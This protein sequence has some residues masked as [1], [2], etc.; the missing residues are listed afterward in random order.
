M[1]SIALFSNNA[2]STLALAINSGATTAQLSS[3]TGALFPT[4]TGTNYFIGTFTDAATGAQNE[5]VKVTGRSG[6]VITF[7]RAQE[8]TSAR[9]WAAGDN[10]E[11][12]WTAGEA[13]LMLQQGQA[14]QQAQNYGV[15]VGSVDTLAVTLS[16]APTAYSDLQ[17][18]PV[19]VLINGPNATT[20]PT[21]NVNGL[22][23]TAIVF[24]DGS[25][26][27]TGTFSNGYI[28][29]FFYTGTQFQYSGQVRRANFVEIQFGA[30]FPNL[31]MPMVPYE[32]A[33][34]FQ[35]IDDSSL[36]GGHVFLPGNVLIQWG[37]YNSLGTSPISIT[38][39]EPFLM[40]GN[41]SVTI[42][43]TQ[44]SGAL[45]T[46]PSILVG[47][48]FS[49]TGF[50]VYDCLWNGSTFINNTGSSFRWHAIGKTNY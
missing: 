47:S 29:E 46:T 31:D 45:P 36:N 37:N 42:T 30:S 14:Q 5:I 1:P 16:P 18:A 17:G 22:G 10:F 27:P 40:G 39:A 33:T 2:A 41:T 7:V 34:A 25:A 19:R 12:F 32:F 35:G 28:A 21:L 26:I 20:T 9:T 38:Y 4:I 48:A 13:A 15:N 24:I 8:G 50:T 23:D 3:G 43:G 44:S 11:M 49:N 6:D